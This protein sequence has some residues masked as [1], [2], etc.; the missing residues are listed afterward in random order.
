MAHAIELHPRY[1][2]GYLNLGLANFKLKKDFDALYY[3]KNAEKL[4]PNNPY[5]RNYYQVY[6][7]DLKQRGGMAF[8]RGR[9]DSAAIAYNLWTILT[10]Q[11]Y[12]AWYNLGGAYFNQRKFAL[13]KKSWERCLQINPNYAE[14]KKVLPMITPQMLG[15]EPQTTIVP[16]AQNI[17]R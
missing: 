13:A 8:N 11:D 15:I 3:W 1:V 9:M 4:Y 16:Q 2:N 14:V 5:L 12:E 7:N 17:Q 6:A 10:P